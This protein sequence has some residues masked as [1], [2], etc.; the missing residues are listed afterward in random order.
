MLDALTDPFAGEIARRAL[1]EITLLAVVCGPLGVWVVLFGQSYAAESLAHAALPGLVVAAL[2]GAPL[3]LGAA[4]GLAVAAGAIS[5]TG[6]DRGLG[7]DTA[8]AVV[9]TTLFG[10]G[11]LLALNPDA[12]ARLG[13]IL[14]G[15]PLS[16]SSAEIA[17]SALLA[18]V[19]LASLAVFHRRFALAAFDSQT[20][21]S[22]GAKPGSAELALL[23]L[24]AGATLAAVQALGNLLVVALI[25]APGA[26]ALRLTRRLAPALAFAAGLA[27][28]SG[29]LGLY[30][31]YHLEIA[32]GAA[33]AL[34]AIIIFGLA[35]VF[36]S[37]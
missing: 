12:P 34:A 37:G 36:R 2:A 9:V 35:T 27:L 31:S 13:E 24:L 29:V 22:L 15:D 8:V 33:I 23:I 6:R 11:V 4:G 5:F 26:A 30:A 14:F 19:V 1:V 7:P 16:V 10:A 25:I 17:V 21:R 28:A 20:A 18:A 32:A 3:M